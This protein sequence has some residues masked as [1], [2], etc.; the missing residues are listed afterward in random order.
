MGHVV[1]ALIPF[2]GG[3]YCPAGRL[4][5]RR[6]EAWRRCQVRRLAREVRDRAEGLRRDLAVARA[7]CDRPPAQRIMCVFTPIRRIEHPRSAI[8][9]RDGRRL[10][11][12]VSSPCPGIA[13]RFSHWQFFA[14]RSPRRLLHLKLPRARSR[15]RMPR[16]SRPDR[17]FRRKRPCRKWS[18]RRASLSSW[19]PPSRT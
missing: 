18:S 13:L 3:V 9:L 14:A 15:F 19:S 7:A 6:Q 8:G 4:S 12:I 2:C 11:F 10:C 1:D 16:T 17:R 5:V